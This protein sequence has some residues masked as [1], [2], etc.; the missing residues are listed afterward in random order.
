MIGAW[1]RNWRRVFTRN[2]HGDGSGAAKG[3]APKEGAPEVRGR[4]RGFY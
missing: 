4:I 2:L 1:I 3:E